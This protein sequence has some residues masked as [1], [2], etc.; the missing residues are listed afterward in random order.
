MSIRTHRSRNDFRTRFIAPVANAVAEPPSPSYYGPH[1][2]IT[3][4]SAAF[5]YDVS[6]FEQITFGLQN[7]LKQLDSNVCTNAEF[8]VTFAIARRR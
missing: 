8:D 5:R 4:T 1:T 7:I 6:I 3:C 2:D